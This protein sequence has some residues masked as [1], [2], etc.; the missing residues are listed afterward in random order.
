MVKSD[1]P[2]KTGEKLEDHLVR[3]VIQSGFPLEIEVS[4]M[5]EKDYEVENNRYYFD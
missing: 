5:L 1:G 4:S 3:E 2:V